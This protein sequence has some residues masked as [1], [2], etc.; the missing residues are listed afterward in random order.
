MIF[1]HPYLQ[2]T[3]LSGQD[4]TVSNYITIIHAESPHPQ[5]VFYVL[6]LRYLVLN[7]VMKTDA[8]IYYLLPNEILKSLQL[9]DSSSSKMC[10]MCHYK[11]K[12]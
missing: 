5:T 3:R 12:L 6:I 9:A 10:Y 2:H 1:L 4:I 7:W 8:L 11:H